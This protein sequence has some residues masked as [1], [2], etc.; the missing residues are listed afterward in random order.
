M[1]RRIRWRQF[2]AGFLLCALGFMA[3][4]AAAIG[5]RQ[6]EYPPPSQAT[7]APLP[8]PE[9]LPTSTLSYPGLGTDRLDIQ[10]APIGAQ[11]S[12]E[13]FANPLG[14]EPDTAPPAS[15]QPSER[16]LLILWVGFVA[17]VLLLLTSIVGSIMLFTRRNES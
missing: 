7:A 16:G 10:P 5:P 2:V 14:A 11:D 1:I 8:S 9:A 15:P 13:P 3:A 17:T 12:G 6:D 4:R